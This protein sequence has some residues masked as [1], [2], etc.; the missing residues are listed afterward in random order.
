MLSA[1]PARAQGTPRAR[2]SS[3]R[4][5]EPTGVERVL[6]ADD[7]IVSKTDLKG[8][9]TYANR[10]FLR[11][12]GFSELELLG[13]AHSIVRHPAMPRGA[14]R[15]MWETIEAGSEF[16][17]YVLNLAKTGDHYWVF[18]H[19]TPTFDE[20]GTIIGYHSNRRAPSRAAIAR[21]EPIYARLSEIER[22]HAEPASAAGAS[23]CRLA[24]ELESKG[25]SYDRFVFSL[26]EEGT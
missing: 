9:I 11:I 15:L 21:V 22:D 20:R 19:I 5:R 4:R 24:A 18:A 13:A 6:G 16:F 3:T 14:F 25:T 23:L 7:L 8:R 10:T 12:S 26:A 1:V 17:G 2:E